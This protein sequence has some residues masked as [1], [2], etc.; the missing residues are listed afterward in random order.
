MPSL[1]LVSPKPQARES[2]LTGTRHLFKVT[3][4]QDARNFAPWVVL[5][6]LLSVTSVLAYIWIFP[7]A[8]TR[9]QLS[10]TLSANPA[11]SLIFG[12][13]G[14]ISTT[15]GFNTWRSLALGGFFASLMTIFIVVRYTRADEDSGQA[16]LFASGVMGRH[17]RL[18]TALGV[19]AAASV[20][21][22]VVSFLLTIAFGAAPLATAL[23]CATF[24]AH[25]L[26]FAGVGAVCAQIAADARTAHTLAVAFAGATFLLRG[27]LDASSASPWTT[28]LTPQGWLQEVAPG[29][30]NNLWPFAA[31]AGFAVLT[32][33]L[34]FILQGRRDFG[35]GLISP[36]PGPA[37]VGAGAKV[38]WLTW[39]LHRPSVIAWLVGLT[40]LGTVFGF[41]SSSF[42]ELF[43]TDPG[44]AALLAHGG[45]SK[46]QL[47]FGLV[48]TLI[49]LIA[50]IASVSGVQ[51]ALR[52]FTEEAAQRTAPL[53]AGAVN[54]QRHIA[55][56]IAIAL[57]TSSLALM[58]AVTALGLVGSALNA[59]LS[60]VDVIKQGLL[61]LPAIW[62]LVGVALAVIGAKPAKRM[63]GWLAIV[64]TFAITVFG[65][66]FNLWHWILGISPL[67]HVP[68][69]THGSGLPAGWWVL[70]ALSVALLAVSV[71]GYRRRDLA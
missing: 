58:L 27:Y 16:E 36:A 8:S 1:A 60:A 11:L 52:L 69:I 17:T 33:A 62:V 65:P 68:I 14:D 34:A 9:A 15:E 2:S 31:A 70:I 18:A 37:G 49:Q 40:I 41:V 46:D 10:Q 22:G 56:Y 26:M 24:T 20:A 54:R 61:T 6:S 5:I 51:I 25:G 43:T 21:L 4:K 12:K 67:Y 30:T 29:T 64:A 47:F 28:W 38:F 48:A 53:L 59:D 66:M 50:I 55:T 71:A 63:I 23:L 13:A 42:A 19:A 44:F 57:A 39:S 7:D 35:A 3:L 32:A 45:T